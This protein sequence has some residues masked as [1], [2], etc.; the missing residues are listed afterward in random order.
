M[1]KIS[2]TSKSKFAKYFFKYNK[3]YVVI[4]FKFYDGS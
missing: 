2:V 4:E 3:L 1:D